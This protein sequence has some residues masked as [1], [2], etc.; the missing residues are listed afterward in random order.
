MGATEAGG[1]EKQW[2]PACACAVRRLE[3]AD[4]MAGVIAQC[5]T[6]EAQA[7]GRIPLAGQAAR[8]ECAFVPCSLAAVEA[9]PDPEIVEKMVETAERRERRKESLLAI[10]QRIKKIKFK[11]VHKI[12]NQLRSVC[13]VAVVEH[14]SDRSEI[15]MLIGIHQKIDRSL[16]IFDPVRCQIVP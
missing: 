14:R 11:M 3:E 1:L 12:G 4:P 8:N 6:L 10:I 2:I 15:Q 13:A 5:K 16:G 7:R 9:A